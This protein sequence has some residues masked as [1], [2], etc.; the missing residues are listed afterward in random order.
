MELLPYLTF[1]LIVALI[2]KV[3]QKIYS[4]TKEERPDEYVKGIWCCVHRL[5]WSSRRKVSDEIDLLLLRRSGALHI[6]AKQLVVYLKEDQMPEITQDALVLVK[7]RSVD[8]PIIT[9]AFPCLSGKL[10]IEQ[11]LLEK[12]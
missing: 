1:F 3:G 12:N 7:E 2:A 10:M 11:V 9:F 6:R 5:R 8:D 4:T